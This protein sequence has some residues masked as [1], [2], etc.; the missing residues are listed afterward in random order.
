MSPGSSS[1]E[2]G[3]TPAASNMV[4][5]KCE[6]QF[7][8]IQRPL[9]A[10]MDT[11]CV[12]CTGK[13]ASKTPISIKTNRFLNFQND[14][15]WGRHYYS[16]VMWASGFSLELSVESTPG[17]VRPR[18]L[19]GA[20]SRAPP[21]QSSVTPVPRLPVTT[22]D[23]LSVSSLAWTLPGSGPMYGCSCPHPLPP[24]CLQK[25]LTILILC[26]LTAC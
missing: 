14:S 16:M 8:G 6:P 17:P 15:T 23:L 12:W 20:I 24:V 21:S 9:L 25:F 26:Q 7:Q 1:R 19:G 2:L 22:G 13:H 5:H 18:V 3:W 11:T 10:S 4:V